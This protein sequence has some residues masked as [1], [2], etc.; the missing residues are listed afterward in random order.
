LIIIYRNQL[1]KNFKDIFG[2]I[3]SAFKN[4]RNA[5]VKELISVNKGFGNMRSGQSGNADRNKNKEMEGI[6]ED[7]L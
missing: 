7:D 1:C 4:E 5:F 3:H 6:K 2:T